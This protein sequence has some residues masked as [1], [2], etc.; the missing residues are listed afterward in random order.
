MNITILI[1]PSTPTEVKVSRDPILHQYSLHWKQRWVFAKENQ[2]PR[3]ENWDCAVAHGYQQL[4]PHPSPPQN[5]QFSHNL[6]LQQNPWHWYKETIKHA[7]GQDGGEFWAREIPGWPLKADMTS[8]IQFWVKMPLRG[9]TRGIWTRGWGE[10]SIEAA[11]F[12][13]GS[14]SKVGLGFC[15]DSTQA[16]A[17]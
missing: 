15:E 17:R 5:N 10:L 8:W 4:Q 7:C 13:E 1:L 14:S 9:H 11:I 16:V 6:A 12:T 2:H 3:K